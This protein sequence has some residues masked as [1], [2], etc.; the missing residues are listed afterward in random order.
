MSDAIC[1]LA[2]E[3]APRIEDTLFLA[4]LIALPLLSGP[5]GPVAYKVA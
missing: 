3:W 1:N 2:I 5:D 4:V